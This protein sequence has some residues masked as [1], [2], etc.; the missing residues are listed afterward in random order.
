MWEWV[1]PFSEEV[2]DSDRVCVWTL[3]GQAVLFIHSKQNIV[4]ACLGSQIPLWHKEQNTHIASI[5]GMCPSICASHQKVLFYY[6]EYTFVS[7]EHPDVVLTCLQHNHYCL[8]LVHTHTGPLADVM[9]VRFIKQLWNLSTLGK[10]HF[11]L[12]VDNI[13]YRNIYVLLQNTNTVLDK[14]YFCFSHTD[15]VTV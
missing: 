14:V 13:I 2:S 4:E 6:S 11:V 1:F 7:L 10:T 15:T 12:L 5:G 8:I 3:E 9:N